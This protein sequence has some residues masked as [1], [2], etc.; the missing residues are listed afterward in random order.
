MAALGAQITLELSAT[1]MLFFNEERKRYYP[2]HAN[3]MPAHLTLIYH[4][5]FSSLEQL[6]NLTCRSIPVFDISISDLALFKNGVAY[7]I[8]SESLIQLHSCLC[9]QL[10]FGLSSRDKE[11]FLPHITICNQVTPFKAQRTYE[12]LKQEFTP[13][14]ARAIGITL[15]FRNQEPIF[16][17]FDV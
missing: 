10:E 5:L 11:A 17:Q 4:V 3:K 8:T 7:S 15:N 13:F 16:Q 9:S 6:E 1:D 14:T 2:A 12:R